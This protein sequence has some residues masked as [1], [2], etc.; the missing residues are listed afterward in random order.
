MGC[1]MR[2]TRGRAADAE[3][4]RKI[5]HPEQIESRESL[6]TMPGEWWQGVV[7][8]VFH[9]A[10]TPSFWGLALCI[11]FLLYRLPLFVFLRSRRSQRQPI[12]R[13]KR[14]VRLSFLTRT[15]GRPFTLAETSAAPGQR[16]T[17]HFSMA[18]LSNP[19][20]RT[21]PAPLPV[22]RSDISIS[23]LPTGLRGSSFPGPAQI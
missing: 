4:P 12:F 6:L 15:I 16:L 2:S 13:S 10:Y 18:Q 17:G 9:L 7:L 3:R 21:L 5:E 20:A 19:R 14:R 8:V 11:F 22:P 23:S 1:A